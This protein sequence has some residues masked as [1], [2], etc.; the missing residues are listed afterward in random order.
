MSRIN[1]IYARAKNHCIGVE[2]ALPWHLPKEFAHFKKTTMGCPVI[3]GRKT[4]E[5]H[6]SVL[7]GRLNI[8][9]TRQ[10]DYQAVP[11]I[12][13]AASLEEAFALAQ[14]DSEDVFIIG[15]VSFFTQGLALADRV[16][17]TVVDVEIDGDA[18]LPEFDFSDWQTEVLLASPPDERNSLGFTAYLHQR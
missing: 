10:A 3:M 5:D 11:G 12:V 17:E 9:V 14:K 13:L 7:P 4:Y 8:V 2:G 6:K 15:G 16:F 18:Y 1:L